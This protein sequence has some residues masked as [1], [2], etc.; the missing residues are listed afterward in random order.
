[1]CINQIYFV[2]QNCLQSHEFLSLLFLFRILFT[3]FHFSLWLTCL[4]RAR[5]YVRFT[6]CEVNLLYV[7]TLLQHA[8][9]GLTVRHAM[10][11]SRSLWVWFFILTHPSLAAGY[12][13]DV[14]PWAVLMN[15]FVSWLWSDFH[16]DL[17]SAFA[18]ASSSHV[19]TVCRAFF[20]AYVKAARW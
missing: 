8:S 6:L 3:P 5:L 15:I 18:N 11:R 14:C 13:D 1:M 19:Q 10:S 2:F 16:S 20:P 17:R 4:G 7:T 9:G 12:R